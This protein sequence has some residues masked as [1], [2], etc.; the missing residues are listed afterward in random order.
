MK[1]HLLT[2]KR[3]IEM[4]L[5]VKGKIKMGFLVIEFDF[6]LLLAPGYEI[7]TQALI[8]NYVAHL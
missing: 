6:P 4:I 1:C 3:S 5:V 2:V 8:V 7:K